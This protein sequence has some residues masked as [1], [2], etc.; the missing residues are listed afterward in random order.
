MI[1][2]QSKRA[3]VFGASSGIGFG[4]AKVFAREKAKLVVGSRGGDRLTAAAREC[5]AVSSVNADFTLPGQSRRAVRESIQILGGLDIVVVNTG[6]PHPG[7]FES[8]GRDQ[9]LEGFQSLWLST[10]DAIQEA[11]PT[12]REQKFGR[13]IL[14]GSTSARE[15]IANLTV[16]NGLRSGLLGLLKSLSV[17]VASCGITVNAILPGYIDTERLSELGKTKNELIQH[18]PTGR[19]GT[20]EEVGSLATFLASDQAAYITGQAIAIDG[21]RLK[22]I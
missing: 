4:V 21:G 2:L 14:I 16:S 17:E 13:I 6:G 10:V 19:L 5:S 7:T 20:A 8:L 18:I 11:L 1:S 22:G 9:W 3:L 15:P 12:M